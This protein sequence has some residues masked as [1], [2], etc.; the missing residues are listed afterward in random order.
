MHYFLLGAGLTTASLDDGRALFLLMTFPFY[1]HRFDLGGYLLD[2][3][4]G[5]EGGEDGEDKNIMVIIL[6]WFCLYFFASS[7]DFLAGFNRRNCFGL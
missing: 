6:N 4:F 3:I 1:K 5:Y 7:C 2:E